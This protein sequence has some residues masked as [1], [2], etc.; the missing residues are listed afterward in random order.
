M[1]KRQ[2]I[3]FS[4]TRMRKANPSAAYIQ[5]KETQRG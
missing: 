3:D 2:V 5:E 1:K 4:N